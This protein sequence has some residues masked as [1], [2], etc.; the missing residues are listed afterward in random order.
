[1]DIITYQLWGLSKSKSVKRKIAGGMIWPPVQHTD[2]IKFRNSYSYDIFMNF[3]NIY[4]CHKMVDI[5]YIL[6]ECSHAFDDIGLLK[7]LTMIFALL[8]HV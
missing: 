8:I 4:I 7:C 3:C 5:K 2:H 6:Y 1:M